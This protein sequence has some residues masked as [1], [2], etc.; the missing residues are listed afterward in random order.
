MNLGEFFVKFSNCDR[1]AE[2]LS[3]FLKFCGPC[4][5]FCEV[6]IRGRYMD[7]RLIIIKI[8]ERRLVRGRCLATK[9]A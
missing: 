6:Q 3:I 7:Y 4:V 9:V 8:H 2:S 5:N 1:F